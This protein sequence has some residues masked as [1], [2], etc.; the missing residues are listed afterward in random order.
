MLKLNFYSRRNGLVCRQ[1]SKKSL[2]G[3]VAVSISRVLRRAAVEARGRRGES[4][5]FTTHDPL[6]AVWKSWRPS[7]PLRKAAR[8]QCHKPFW[9]AELSQL[10]TSQY[11]KKTREEGITTVSNNSKTCSS[12]RPPKEQ[13]RA[14]GP[15]SLL[16]RVLHRARENN[17]YWRPAQFQRR[18]ERERNRTMI[19]L[20]ARRPPRRPPRQPR[21]KSPVSVAPAVTTPPFLPP[22]CCR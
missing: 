11:K 2:K 7:Y 18:R 6:F 9:T 4:E 22:K 20:H 17:R 1:L 10:F 13:A 12:K 21:N 3:L 15:T 19:S 8:V 14:A 16:L 5:K